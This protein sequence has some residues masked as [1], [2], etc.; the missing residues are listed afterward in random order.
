MGLFSKTEIYVVEIKHETISTITFENVTLL[1]HPSQDETFFGI[2]IGLLDTGKT[3]IRNFCS[4]MK[5]EIC[6][7]IDRVRTRLTNMLDLVL[8]RLSDKYVHYLHLTWQ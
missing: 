3:I 4:I 5:S 2:V 8:G 6:R 7:R 1:F